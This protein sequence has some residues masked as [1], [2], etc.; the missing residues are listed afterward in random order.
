[1]LALAVALGER[2]ALAAENAMLYRDRLR[3]KERLDLLA[4]SSRLFAESERDLA[5]IMDHLAETLVPRIADS[6]YVRR[7]S[8][9]GR[10]VLTLA[11]RH[12][13]P[14]VEQRERDLTRSAQ[15]ADQGMTGEVIRTGQPVFMPVIDDEEFRRSTA[16]QYRPYVGRGNMKSYLMVPMRA[17]GEILGA[18]GVGRSAGREPFTE[19]DLHLVQR[20]ADRAG[21]AVGTWEAFRL[22]EEEKAALARSREDLRRAQA[23]SAFLA[24][25]VRS[26]NDA[27]VT[28]TLEGRITSW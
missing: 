2:A 8:G 21:L 24:E 5:G 22:L 15:P 4:E 17:R 1:D 9:D 18:L 7:L 11:V 23:A 10:S 14:E 20:I 19:E 27:V 16:P 26:S 12:R 13:D 25:V 28:K 6:C 3:Q